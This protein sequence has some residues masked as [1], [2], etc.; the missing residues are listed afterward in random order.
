MPHFMLE[1]R[2]RKKPKCQQPRIMN[3]MFWAYHCPV[4]NI[5]S[6]CQQI[7]QG[8]INY[9]DII[10]YCKCNALMWALRQQWSSIYCIVTRIII[11]PIRHN[12][13]QIHG[14]RSNGFWGRCKIRILG[15][16]ISANN[17]DYWSF[18]HLQ[19]TFLQQGYAVVWQRCWH[20]C[21]VF[22]HV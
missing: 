3:T 21:I 19:H 6:K 8:T 14:A 15:P 16:S 13:G 22:A 10:M 2:S 7:R 1:L 11:L 4:V 12:I 18:I 5:L 20:Y 9:T 17:I